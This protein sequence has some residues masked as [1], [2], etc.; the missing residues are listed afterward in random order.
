MRMM[1]IFTTDGERPFVG[2]EE[3]PEDISPG[4]VFQNWKNL[5]DED[6]R[7]YLV[8][9]LKPNYIFIHPV[10]GAI[11]RDAPLKLARI[12]DSAGDQLNNNMAVLCKE[13]EVSADFAIPKGEFVASMRAFERINIV[14]EL[15]VMQLVK[16]N[17][18]EMKTIEEALASGWKIPSLE[19]LWDRMNDFMTEAERASD[20]IGDLLDV[21]YPTDK[22]KWGY[23]IESGWVNGN[24]EGF[25]DGA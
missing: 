3:I 20:A 13:M 8:D 1:A 23:L 7:E 6:A 16:D 5:L 19:Y 22:E 10:C 12:S 4:E 24:A 18:D 25:L 2:I 11:L 14:E 9:T 15:D 17:C 21:A